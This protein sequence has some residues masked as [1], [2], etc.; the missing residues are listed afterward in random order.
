MAK[1]LHRAHRQ[2]ERQPDKQ[3]ARQSD[4]R[5]A[6]AHLQGCL[7]AESSTR[8]KNPHTI[9]P[10]YFIGLECERAKLE[11]S[12]APVSMANLLSTILGERMAKYLLGPFR[13]RGG[14]KRIRT[15]ERNGL[16]ALTGGR[17]PDRNQTR[18][19]RGRVLGSSGLPVTRRAA[20]YAGC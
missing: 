13:E 2:N 12:A 5:L 7:F 18:T 11:A 20:P 14:R 4:K 3:S 15:A 6:T 1:H 16:D 17:K 19:R 9:Q 10:R 8:G